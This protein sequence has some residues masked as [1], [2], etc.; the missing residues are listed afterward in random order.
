MRR[1]NALAVLVLAAFLPLA[2]PAWAAYDANEVPLGATEKALLERFPAAHCK[3]LEWKSKAAERR[4]DDSKALIGGVP[5]RI[6][7]YLKRDRVEAFDLR[8]DTKDA[9]RLG[10]FLKKRY[11]APAEER[12]AK[13]EDQRRGE[14]YKVEWKKGEERAV[15]TALST[16]GRA[17]LTVWRGDFED[18]IYRVR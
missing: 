17:S 14:I 10:A 11:G 5:G 16:K 1:V 18:E 15:L 9:E 4:C 13:L 8:F 12:R 2:S 7:F 3:P 6:T